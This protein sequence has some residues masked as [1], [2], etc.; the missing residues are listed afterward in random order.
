M[1][2]SNQENF[3]PTQRLSSLGYDWGICKVLKDFLF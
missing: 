2:L 1:S 3:K